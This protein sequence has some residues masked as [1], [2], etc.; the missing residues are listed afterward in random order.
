M[1]LRFLLNGLS[2]RVKGMFPRSGH[3]HRRPLCVSSRPLLGP[4]GDPDN[5][6][7]RIPSLTDF[8]ELVY[9]N[10]INTLRNWFF[11]HFLITPYFDTMFRRV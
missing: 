7:R 5:L 3:Q 4:A 8:P 1:S 2:R 6:A 10:L 11:V 9:P